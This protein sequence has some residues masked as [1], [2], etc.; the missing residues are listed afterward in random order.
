M[1]QKLQSLLGT[2]QKKDQL[3]FTY[4][5]DQEVELMGSYTIRDERAVKKNRGR[6]AEAAGP[7][8]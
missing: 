6:S 7:Q 5:I 1:E 8:R 4:I 2:Y 3:L